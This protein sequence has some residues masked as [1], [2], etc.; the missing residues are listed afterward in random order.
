VSRNVGQRVVHNARSRKQQKAELAQLHQRALALQQAG[1][2][3]EAQA[4]CRQ[5]LK[6]A[7]RHF[8]ALCL[9]AMF[10]YQARNYHDAEGHLSQ[11]I[12]VE[13]RSVKA[14]LNR[15]V[16]LQAQQRFEE[17]AAG[18]R[19]AI[20]L[21]PGSAV[22]RNNLGNTC[23]MLNRLDE[24]IEN[25][26]RA[27]AIRPDF[28][29]AWYNR[30][31]ALAQLGR[32]QEALCDHQRALALDPGFADALN[33]Q[34][35]ALGALGRL[36]EALLGFDRALAINPNF[37]TALNNRGNTLRELERP[38]E[39]LD[40]YDRALALSPNFAE[41]LNGRGT[42]LSRL[43]DFDAA[44]ASFQRALA[45]RPHYAEALANLGSARLDLDKADEALSDFDRALA[46][47]PG[48][49][50]AWL[51]RGHALQKRKRISEAVAC[52]ERALSLEPASYRAR[53][54][55][56]HCLASLGRSDEAIAKFDDALA[57]KPDF[58]EAISVKIFVL[59]FAPGA[60]FAEQR[61]A[62]RLW[63]D[64]IGSKLA[65]RPREP[66]R[67]GRDP[68]RRLVLGYVSAD[69]RDHSAAHAF[70][71]V[72]QHGDKAR[73]E[74]V[75]YSCSPLHDWMTEAFRGM[76][77]RW[78]DASQWSDDRLADQIRQD[79]VDILIDLSGHTGGHRLGVFARKPAPIQVH[80]W[81]H[82][83]PP[84]LPTIDYVFSDA[85]SIPPAVR[86]LFHETIYDLP[87]MITLDPLP[88]E[89]PRAELPALSNGFVTFGV[90][91]RI[92]KISD[93]AVEI[94]AQILDRLP[95][96]KLL[97]KDHAIEDALVRDNLLARFARFG[98]PSERIELLGATSRPDHLCALNRV[99]IALDPFPQNGGVSTFEALQMGVPV[100]A[101]LGNTL[102]SR[103]AG[104]IL[105]AIGMQDWVAENPG[106]YLKIAL[107]QAGEIEQLAQLRRA[108]PGRIAASPAGNPTAY[109]AEVGKAYRSMWQ[110]YCAG[111]SRMSSMP[112]FSSQDGAT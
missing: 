33:G 29:N 27:I 75:C 78:R 2:L 80:G 107:A 61:D 6:L 73:F 20:A 95:R 105:C 32:Y 60:G 40:S 49:V 19:R 98:V 109:A 48:L 52:C 89:V 70:K 81:G 15:S 25:Y 13:P 28:A 66:H 104:A 50:S 111:E 36:E 94:W 1:R 82:G 64:R 88:A 30:G 46:L 101:K 91:N 59:D 84:G 42:I 65:A 106:D 8:D 93:P 74:T 63:W 21:D 87:C 90:F 100:V 14:H 99:D 41:A 62:R 97:I 9:L 56:G 92:S 53:V 83:T 11:A 68:H 102:S 96:S 10:E 31:A 5:L 85:V 4:V 38:S 39:A 67:N 76:A 110:R 58:G 79:G 55:M 54:L 3:L 22:A 23:R 77:E 112:P 51:G 108:L 72:L 71:P 17:A 69:F 45:I 16:V 44:V 86:G 57:I 7:P 43:R 26:D 12:E 35:S 37:V 18:Y 47:E 24:A 103:V 34:G